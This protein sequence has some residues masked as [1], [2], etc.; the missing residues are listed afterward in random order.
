MVLEYMT[1]LFERGTIE[2][3]AESL[4]LV[5]SAAVS[6]PD[7][8]AGGLPMLG[9]E[10]AADL[11]ARFACRK[12]QPGHPAAPLAHQLFEQAAAEN[13]AAACLL[14]EGQTLTYRLVRQLAS[15]LAE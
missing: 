6:K 12:L 11:L 5:L 8:L 15:N 9:K 3:L 10:G 7:S 14:H 13:P 4:G 2:G 1:E